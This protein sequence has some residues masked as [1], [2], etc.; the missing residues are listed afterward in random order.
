MALP[1]KKISKTRRDRRRS[2]LALKP[3]TPNKCAHCK[4][5][6]RPHRVCGNCGYYAGVEVKTPEE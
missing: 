6:A 1:K 4:Q 3:S 2:H 5:P